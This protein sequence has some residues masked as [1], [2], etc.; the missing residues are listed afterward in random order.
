[1][2]RRFLPEK[3]LLFYPLRADVVEKAHKSSWVGTWLLMQGCRPDHLNDQSGKGRF[4]IAKRECN[5][6]FNGQFHE[7]YGV[8]GA[9]GCQL[10]LSHYEIESPYCT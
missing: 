2:L 1:M 7:K 4:S 6:I 10:A 9:C 8:P 3:I 5:S